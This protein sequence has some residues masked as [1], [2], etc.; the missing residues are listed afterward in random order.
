MPRI[1]RPPLPEVIDARRQLN[2]YIERE[3]IAVN[4][5]AIRAD[6]PQ[7]TLHRFLSGRTKSVTPLIARVLDYAEIELIT[8]IEPQ[9]DVADH[10]KLRK[11]L[12]AAC[13]GRVESVD[14][15]A[16]LIEALTPVLATHRT[17]D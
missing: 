13:D 1:A 3:G 17:S 10:P 8:G 16:A 4:A 2:A 15:L 12:R 7:P 6:V 11:A 9:Y 14:L 5:L